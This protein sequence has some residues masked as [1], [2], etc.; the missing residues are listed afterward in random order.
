MTR[1]FEFFLFLSIPQDLWGHVGLGFRGLGF[2]GL[3]V[4]GLGL[5]V[6]I[7]APSFGG[8][9]TVDVYHTVALQGGWSNGCDEGEQNCA[10]L[11]T[12]SYLSLHVCTHLP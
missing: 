12:I 1:T 11:S 3:G 4:M 2:R 9:E 5:R 7:M 10:G 8:I 6:A